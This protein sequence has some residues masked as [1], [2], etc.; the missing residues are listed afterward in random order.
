MSSIIRNQA[1]QAYSPWRPRQFDAP[2]DEPTGH[3][4]QETPT[5]APIE[6]EPEPTTLEIAPGVSLPTAED[7]ERIH[8]EAWKAGYDAG[9]EEGSARGRIEAAELHQL[10]QGLDEAMTKFD[11]EV[12]EEIQALA[13][14]IARQVVRETLS[15][16]SETILAVVR[17]ALLN[18]PQQ[19]ATIHVN[20]ADAE[21]LRRYLTEHYQGIGHRI[22]EDDS[23]LQGGCMIESSGA[24]IDAQVQTR[25][26][27]VIENLTR[28]A[29]DFLD[30]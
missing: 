17:E 2:A 18:L 21:N 3:E 28:S 20:P 1:S 14:E 12:A 9:Y 23:V 24:Q 5:P 30:E 27:R 13:I 29:A 10:M 6:A 25:W 16:K 26:R 7:V 15:V 19:S 22:A 8:N 11:Q 4:L